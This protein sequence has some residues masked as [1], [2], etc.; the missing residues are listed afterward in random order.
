MM[1]KLFTAAVMAVVG[2]VAFKRVSAAKAEQ[3]LWTE[4]DSE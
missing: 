3:N 2:F 4:A 1:K